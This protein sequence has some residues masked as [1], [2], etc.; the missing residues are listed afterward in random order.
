MNG[1]A[2]GEGMDWMMRRICSVLATSVRRIFPSVARIFNCLQAVHLR[3]PL[4]DVF[5]KP[6]NRC[7]RFLP[8]ADRSERRSHSLRRNTILPVP[9]PRRHGSFYPPF[10]P[11]PILQSEQGILARFRRIFSKNIN[12]IRSFSLN[13]LPDALCF[14]GYSYIMYCVA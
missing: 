3:P 7:W 12:L 6:P 10:S 9:R 14:F 4:S 1:S 11:L 13:T 5:S 8:L 2:F